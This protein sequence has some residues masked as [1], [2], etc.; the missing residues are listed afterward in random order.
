[1]ENAQQINNI[2]AREKR[3]GGGRRVEEKRREE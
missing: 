2:W 1:L 3:K